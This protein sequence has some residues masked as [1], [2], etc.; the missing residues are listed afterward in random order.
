MTAGL[1]SCPGPTRTGSMSARH[2]IRQAGVL[3]TVLGGANLIRLSELS[4]RLQRLGEPP[5]WRVLG[6]TG[7]AGSPSPHRARQGF[8]PCPRLITCRATGRDTGTRPRWGCPG[9]HRPVRGPCGNRTRYP[10]ATFPERQATMRPVRPVLRTAGT[11]RHP[12]RPAHRRRTG[13]A[14]ASHPAA[15][16]LTPAAVCRHLPEG[17]WDLVLAACDGIRPP[18]QA[19]PTQ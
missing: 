3:A 18:Q 4:R 6:F 9:P 1:P 14:R 19:H 13:H 8:A 10:A 15:L 5:G 12:N 11:T 2:V 7:P 17:R 16:G